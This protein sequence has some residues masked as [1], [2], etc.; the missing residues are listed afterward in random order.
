VLEEFAIPYVVVYEEDDPKD[1]ANGEIA[2]CTKDPTRLYIHKPNLEASV[3]FAAKQRNKVEAA[4]T[5][6]QSGLTPAQ[7]TVLQAPWRRPLGDVRPDLLLRL[8]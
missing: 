6:L 8:I 7:H 5:F 2:A 1:E 3:G 4:L